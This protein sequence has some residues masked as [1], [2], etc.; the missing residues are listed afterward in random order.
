MVYGRFIR[1][2]PVQD[3]NFWVLPR[4][5]VL[6]RFD[7]NNNKI[8]KNTWRYHYLYLCANNLH[9]MIYSSWDMEYDRLKLV[10]MGHFLPF[11]PPKN[12]PKSELW[13]NES[14]YVSI[15]HICTKNHNH[16]MYASWDM[17]YNRHNFLSFWSI[18]CPHI[19]LITPKIKILN[20]C[21]KTPWRYYPITHVYLKWRSWCM[22][23]EI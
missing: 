16:M 21:K 4:V 5:V 18:F 1:R 15:L 2:P 22:V 3:D 8:K 12:P 19:L 11:Y 7:C 10:I 20:K 23:P 17:E 13:K 9:D 14:G 6:Y